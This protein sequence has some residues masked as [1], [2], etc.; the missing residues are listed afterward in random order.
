M[1]HKIVPIDVIPPRKYTKGSVYDE[2]LNEFI[3]MDIPRA[4]VEM[5]NKTTGQP[6]KGTYLTSRLLKRIKERKLGTQIRASTRNGLAYLIQ[7]TV[8]E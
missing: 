1:T 4:K 5:N 8:G 2:L 6:L 7:A 3:R